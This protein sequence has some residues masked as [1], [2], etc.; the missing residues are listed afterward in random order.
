MAAGMV[1][2]AAS[3]GAP[4]RVVDP[5]AGSGRFLFA[6]AKRF[7]RARLVAVETDPLAALMLRAN[8]E[9]LDLSGR[10]TLLLDDYRAVVRAV[11]FTSGR[12]GN[13]CP[14]AALHGA[15]RFQ[16]CGGCALRH[17]EHR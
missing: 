7:P 11:F 1:G 13:I 5:G 16:S 9:V 6:A 2:W 4:S 8:A 10:L 14:T 3:V 17:A 12:R 15:I